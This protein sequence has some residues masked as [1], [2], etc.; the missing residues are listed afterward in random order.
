MKQIIVKKND[1]GIVIITPNHDKYGDQEGKRPFS[2]CN[3]LGPYL[4][5]GLEWFV[6][7]NSDLPQKSQMESRVQWYHDGN[8]VKVD[9]EWL[10]RI[11]PI[12][13]IRKKH[14]AGC[15]KKIDA[16]LAKE[17]PDV[18]TI[19]KLQ[20]EKEKCKGWTE[21]EWYEQALKNIDERVADGE[22]DKPLI[23]KKL[24]EKIEGIK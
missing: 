3:G 12:Q 8:I 13:L 18:I 14:Q 4:R 5:E 16:E 11:M 15:D 23:R 22:A 1:G 24:T 9:S 20:R 6:C 19:A 10:I 2:E 7:N 17:N 21:N